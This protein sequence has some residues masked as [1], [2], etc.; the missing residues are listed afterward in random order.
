MYDT[1]LAYVVA[2]AISFSP[3]PFCASFFLICLVGVRI[4]TSSSADVGWMPT[5]ESITFLVTPM[6]T[7]TAKPC[8]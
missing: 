5:V 4:V 2:A 7:A 6:R 1:A 3:F 8:T